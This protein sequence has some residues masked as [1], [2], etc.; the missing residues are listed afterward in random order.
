MPRRKNAVP[1]LL[2]HKG[3]GL[4]YATFSGVIRYF[5]PWPADHPEPPAATRAAF[6]KALAEWLTGG[7]SAPPEPARRA[8]PAVVAL[9]PGGLTVAELI[10]RF[11]AWALDY[12]R[13]KDGRPTGET[14]NIKWALRP[15]NALFGSTSAAQFGPR[16]FKAVREVMVTGYHHSEFGVQRPLSRRTVNSRARRVKQLF[17]WGVAEELVPP[18]VA[19]ALREVPALAAGR[20]QARETEPVGPIDEAVVQAT[21]PRLRPH[22]A[23]MVRLQ[24]LTGMRPAE[25][26]RLRLADLDRTGPVWKY[27]P[28]R[29]K[30]AYR[31]KRRTVFIGPEAQRV[32]AEFI[33]IRCPLCGVEGRPPRIGSRDGSVCGPCADRLDEHGVCGPW[34]RQEVHDPVVFVF[35]PRA[36]QQERHADMRQ[37][38]KSMVQPSQV[39]RKKT[40]PR[41]TPGDVYSRHAYTR[42]IARAAAAAGVASWHPNQLRHTHATR[43][44]RLFGL[45]AAQVLLGHSSAAVTE[46]YAERDAALG[47]RVALQIG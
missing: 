27:H 1:S 29:H 5:G 26:C 28:P 33:R 23:G 14:E 47:E 32:I 12:Y 40:A 19:W 18:A 25:A 35:S 34:P 20:T 36:D 24:L 10:A 11:W 43:V 9:D 8:A 46:I 3:K 15:L 41:R 37:S 42:G 45:E 2:R 44:R 13:D 30:T 39:S 6:D 4:A 31:G 38:R 17:R 16:R 21:L 22:P 7:R